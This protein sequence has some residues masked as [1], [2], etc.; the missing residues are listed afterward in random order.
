MSTLNGPYRQIGVQLNR[1]FRNDQNAN[2]LDIY[3]DVLG[4]ANQLELLIINASGNSNPEVIA[5]RVGQ[6]GT[7]Y[8]SLLARLNAE[9]LK[10]SRRV[11]A[12]TATPSN[13]SAGDIWLKELS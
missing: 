5:A 9:F 7:T 10:L 1:D 4:L 12:S 3:A 2:L 13:S 8:A 6:D 11:T